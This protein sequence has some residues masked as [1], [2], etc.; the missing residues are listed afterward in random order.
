MLDNIN[1]S[2]HFELLD[3]SFYM[4]SI[5]LRKP[6]DLSQHMNFKRLSEDTVL[7]ESGSNELE[8]A[9]PKFNEE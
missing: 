1:R 3:R 4:N 8:N 2:L 6:H 7:P 9:I 5:P